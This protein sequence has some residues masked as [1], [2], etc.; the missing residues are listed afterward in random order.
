MKIISESDQTFECDITAPCFAYLAENEVEFIRKSK[1]MVAF[2]KGENLTKQGAF[3]SYVLFIIEGVVKQYIE[4]D[5]T[6]SHNLRIFKT[7]EFVGLSAIYN[8]NRFNYSASA[9]TDTRVYLIEK[10]VMLHILEINTIFA[11]KILKNYCKQNNFLFTALQNIIYKQMNGRMADALLYLNEEMYEGTSIFPL[12][13]RKDIADFAG[14]STESAVKIL[15]SFE[16]DE[17]IRL[18]EK[19]IQIIDK[20]KLEEI[21]RRG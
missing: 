21:S 20:T 6:K 12:L 11:T 10:E 18:D 19:N 4:G 14:T 3:A 1:T 16:R 9:L 2:R 15:K 5:I 13:S 17:I 8:E 7:G